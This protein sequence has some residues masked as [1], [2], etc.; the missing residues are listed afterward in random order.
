MSP[1][2]FD[3]EKHPL[4]NWREDVLWRG[5]RVAQHARAHTLSHTHTHA[6]KQVG[7]ER[8]RC[9]CGCGNS[10]SGAG[11]LLDKICEENFSPLSAQRYYITRNPKWQ[12][13]FVQAFENP[14]TFLSDDQPTTKK[15]SCCGVDLEKAHTKTC[16]G[17]LGCL[18]QVYSRLSKDRILI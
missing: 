16:V 13:A 8:V 5:C 2:C 6:H 10:C 15:P 18:C 4:R 14:V 12:S 7:E 1:K 9:V 3:Y 17:K 11:W